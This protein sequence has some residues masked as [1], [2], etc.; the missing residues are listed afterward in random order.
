M[1]LG[2]GGVIRDSLSGL[3]DGRDLFESR[4]ALGRH[5]GRC[6]SRQEQSVEKWFWRRFFLKIEKCIFSHMIPVPPA[7]ASAVPRD[8]TAIPVLLWPLKPSPTTLPGP[9]MMP[10]GPG[11]VQEPGIVLDF[12]LEGW[13]LFF[14]GSSSDRTRFVKLAM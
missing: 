7:D 4:A 6:T 14:S 3:E 13:N 9:R 8:P 12:F 5:L 1:I 10:R 2:P 11:T